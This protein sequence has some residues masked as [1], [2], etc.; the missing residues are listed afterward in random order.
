MSDMS[1]FNN[2]KEDSKSISDKVQEFFLQNYF[3]NVYKLDTDFEKIPIETHQ[4]NIHD[5][6]KILYIQ[7]YVKLKC[8]L[9][10]SFDAD[11][12]KKLVDD[13]LTEM[14]KYNK[15]NKEEALKTKKI[16]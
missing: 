4:K 1:D 12:T 16:K 5:I 15:S 6:T 13:F 9:A 7:N 8:K 10:G 3:K 14:E 11:E 2:E